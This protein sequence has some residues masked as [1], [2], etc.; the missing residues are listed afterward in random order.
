MAIFKTIILATISLSLSTNAQS[1]DSLYA[2][3]IDS[4]WFDSYDRKLLSKK[5]VN[6][7]GVKTGYS[8]YKSSGKIRSITILNKPT[9]ENFLFFYLQDK[10][11]MISPSG[12]QPY[13]ILDDKVFYAKEFR[14]TA[15]Q[16]QGFISKA[17]DYLQQA[18]LK[19]KP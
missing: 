13:F 10:I 6:D 17:Y 3:K 19:I 16:I 9:K 18:Y 5:W 2:K 7:A 12:Q 4:I 8:Y 11:V 14:H 1:Q 15:E